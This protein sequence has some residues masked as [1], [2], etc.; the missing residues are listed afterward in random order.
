MI[1]FW[2]LFC[3]LSF[4]K[5]DGI[6]GANE[7][8]PSNFST[9]QQ[10]TKNKEHS[11][12][13]SHAKTT[14]KPH[15]PDLNIPLEEPLRDTESDRPKTKHQRKMQKMR[16][17]G[18]LLQHRERDRLRKILFR[19]NLTDEERQK[20]SRKN[21][22]RLNERLRAVSLSSNFLLSSFPFIF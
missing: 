13:S 12:L 17:E 1:E 2:L 5:I 4:L 10:S 19:A 9:I 16:K 11:M 18:K 20:I 3:L 8:K 7:N 15:L 21:E 22:E 14:P 6:C